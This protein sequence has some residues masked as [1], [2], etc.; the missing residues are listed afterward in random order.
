[1]LIVLRSGVRKSPKG[2]G[3]R[4]GDTVN[5]LD[6]FDDLSAELLESWLLQEGNDIV[7]SRYGIRSDD[8]RK[9]LHLGNDLSDASEVGLN[10][11]ICLQNSP[12]RVD[13]DSD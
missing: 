9:P 3:E 8:A 2:A 1:M 6:T 11:N 13:W 10:K 7:R 5:D 4:A 12:I